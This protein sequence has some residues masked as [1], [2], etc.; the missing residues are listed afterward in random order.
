MQVDMPSLPDVLEDP[1]F[2]PGPGRKT[3]IVTSSAAPGP[4]EALPQHG[5]P[6]SRRCL[7]KRRDQDAHV[8]WC[9][10]GERT[11]WSPQ[12]LQDPASKGDSQEYFLGTIQSGVSSLPAVKGSRGVSGHGMQGVKF[13]ENLAGSGSESLQARVGCQICAVCS[14]TQQA[15]VCRPAHHGGHH[16]GRAA[17]ED[18]HDCRARSP[19]LCLHRP[20]W[21][22]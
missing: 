20:R 9:S 18:H 17:A 22:R 6:Q 19:A 15:G 7:R 16:P 10:T 4:S 5:M 11:Q 14:V 1:S 8:H 21:R 12:Q 3:I 13:Q 2:A